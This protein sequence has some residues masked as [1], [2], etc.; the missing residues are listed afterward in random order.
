MATTIEIRV[1][2]IGDFSDVEIVDVMVAAGDTV[3]VD[4]SLITLETDKAAMDVPATAAGK[5]TLPVLILLRP[6]DTP[7]P[8]P[9]PRPRVGTAV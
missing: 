9:R 7:R 3:D 2:D 8:R 5:P 6:R 1:P 4:D